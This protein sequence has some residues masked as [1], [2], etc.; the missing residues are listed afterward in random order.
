MPRFVYYTA[1]TLN[2]F[3]ADEDNSLAWLFAVE[4]SAMPDL[5]A[6]LGE[7]AVNVMGSTTYEWVLREEKILETPGRWQQLDYLGDRPAFVFTSRDLP[8]P[9]GADVRLVRGAVTDS[10]GEITTAADGGD[11]WLL[12]GGDLVG[13]F[14]EAGALDEI[15]VSFAP[16]TVPSG[17]PL[18]PRRIGPDALSLRSVQQ[19]GQ[20]AHLT[21]DVRH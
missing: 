14:W 8:R 9:E 10:L 21:Y 15:Q 1:S 17:A 3:L 20:F 6:Q 18:L 7:V 19:F 4:S 13:Q 11:V 12:G 2:G 5:S 16:A